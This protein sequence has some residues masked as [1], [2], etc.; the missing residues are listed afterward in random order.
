MIYKK[1]CWEILNK[2]RTKKKSINW[3]N[4][5]S[6][7]LVCGS[8]PLLSFALI[9]KKDEQRTEKAE[10][11]HGVEDAWCSVEYESFSSSTD[12]TWHP[13]IPSVRTTWICWSVCLSVSCVCLSI[14]IFLVKSRGIPFQ[15]WNHYLLHFSK[16]KRRPPRPPLIHS[17]CL[18]CLC[19]VCVSLQ[20]SLCANKWRVCPS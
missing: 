20:S 2:W 1:R 8:I 3:N 6:S 14:L 18:S 15:L 16:Q 13:F 10:N 11:C 19:S 12:M 7:S 5:Y 9:G 4:S 17:Y